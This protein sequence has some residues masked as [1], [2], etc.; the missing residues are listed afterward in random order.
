MQCHGC[1][2]CYNDSLLTWLL[3]RI[4]ANVNTSV[5]FSG[6]ISECLPLL[7]YHG[8]Q[9]SAAR[10]DSPIKHPH[11]GLFPL[12]TS[13]PS[14][15]EPSPSTHCPSAASPYSPCSSASPPDHPLALERTTASAG[16]TC[17]ILP[18][19]NLTSAGSFPKSLD[20][21]ESGGRANPRAELT[22]HAGPHSYRLARQV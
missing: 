19:S 6:I 3:I 1:G 4:R 10:C 14:P 20:H 5:I 22:P 8:D 12:G 11:T 2:L 15:W 13:S 7:C 9:R 18:C 17:S 21:T 16:G